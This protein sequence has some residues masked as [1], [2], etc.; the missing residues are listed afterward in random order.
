LLDFAV[1]LFQQP[2]NEPG[3]T[4]TTVGLNKQTSVYKGREVYSGLV[5]E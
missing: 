4:A 5:A 2:A 1:R 3:F